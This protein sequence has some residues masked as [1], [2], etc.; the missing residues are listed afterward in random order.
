M[1]LLKYSI[2]VIGFL[3]SLTKC[4]TIEKER[5]PIL[6][7]SI[8]NAPQVV[9][10]YRLDSIPTI[11]DT[12]N[13]QPD[14]FFECKRGHLK[15]DFY[16][17]SLGNES[18]NLIL[19]ADST[20]VVNF[21]YFNLRESLRFS[22][23]MQSE[24]LQRVE[25]NS[26]QYKQ[27]LKI[28]ADTILGMVG[29]VTTDSIINRMYLQLDS[30][31]LRYRENL[32]A[33]M[34]GQD[35]SLVVLPM[36]LQSVGNWSLFTLP[37]EKALFIK[38]QFLLS[39]KFSHSYQV[40]QFSKLVKEVI[41]KQDGVKQLSLGDKFPD[42]DLFTPWNDPLPINTLNGKNVLVIVWSPDLQ[43]CR[44]RNKEIAKLMW[45]YRNQG[46][47][48]YMINMSTSSDE[49]KRVIKEDELNCLHVSDL[50][51]PFSPVIT[52]L[53]ISSLPSS[54]LLNRDGKVVEMNLWG[55]NLEDAII[56]ITKNKNYHRNE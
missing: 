2:F 27:A 48:T 3:I 39:Q 10:L 49:W 35:S 55:E 7:G 41:A 36:L 56:Q 45:R 23:C 6:K 43:T 4:S 51:G 22:G 28:A 47:E 40:G 12:L 29:T 19:Y 17:L 26:L 5:V 30:V 24:I 11:V 46:L 8:V 53:G 52:A 14:G 20:T 33:M 32:E 38:S 9:L 13:V 50:K 44:I 1:G 25:S 18:I 15:S 31:T 16:R 37:K 34:V 54:F 42:L 21:D